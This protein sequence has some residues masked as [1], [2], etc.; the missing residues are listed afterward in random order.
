MLH[1]LAAGT[2]TA[3]ADSVPRP[4]SPESTGRQSLDS[5][6]AGKPARHPSF[7]SLP[8]SRSRLGRQAVAAL[9]FEAVSEIA[10]AASTAAMHVR[11]VAAP[12]A[13][14]MLAQITAMAPFDLT[15][16]EGAAA[17]QSRRQGR[18]TADGAAREAPPE[19]RGA[20]SAPGAA[21]GSTAATAAAAQSDGQGT[22]TPSTG[23]SP[24][25]ARGKSS[26]DGLQPPQ[27]FAWSQ[28][29]PQSESARGLGGPPRDVMW[30]LCCA[31]AYAALSVCTHA[32]RFGFPR[33]AVATEVLDRAA[34]VLCAL[35]VERREDVP[36]AVTAALRKQ[37]LCSECAESN[38]CAPTPPARGDG[39]QPL[40]AAAHEA[41]QTLQT[42]W[43][44]VC[45]GCLTGLSGFVKDGLAQEAGHYT[46]ALATSVC[47]HEPEPTL[48]DSSELHDL[49]GLEHHGLEA[50]QLFVAA[51]PH[52]EMQRSATSAQPA[53]ARGRRAAP[54]SAAYAVQVAAPGLAVRCPAPLHCVQ[55]WGDFERRVCLQVDWSRA[56][57]ARQAV[58]RALH[59]ARQPR[60][61]FPSR[62]ATV[63]G[64]NLR[65]SEPQ[66]SS[67][68]AEAVHLIVFVHGFAGLSTDLRVLCNHIREVAPNARTLCLQSF[69][70]RIWRARCRVVTDRMSVA[71]V[72]S[73]HCPQMS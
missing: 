51:F 39:A 63:P 32:K 34:S 24:E 60:T 58:L 15:G 11:R 23:P 35:S 42:T 38:S 31:I 49:D 50:L 69:Q 9:P 12:H 13:H 6:A 68:A 56:P 17:A 57:T 61:P 67:K 10:G 43:D 7:A 44:E 20:K 65:R 40:A 46:L 29:Q 45:E 54:R 21:A 28:P 70:V 48:L 27:H 2:L 37:D 36:H 4:R 64:S 19:P 55:T 16:G 41:W 73:V 59:R 30:Q 62:S 66:R 26:F 33:M 5:T 47:T 8:R 52:A 18:A 25:Y 53:A 3:P 72:A 22:P 71:G 14:A 1:R